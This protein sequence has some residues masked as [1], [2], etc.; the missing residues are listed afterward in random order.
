MMRL[1]KQ[2]A[3]IVANS[4]AFE[5]FVGLLEHAGGEQ[6]NLFR[7]LT[8]HR[9][10]EPKAYP[11]LDPGLISA[12]PETFEG[13]MKYLATNYQVVSVLDVVEAFENQ[14]R[15][16]L[17]LR[18]VMITF[19]DA[20][21][22]FEKHAWPILKYYR[23]PVTL[24]VPTAFPDHPERLFWWDRVFNAIHTTAK[25]E[26]NTSIGRIPISTASQRKQAF[27]RL[28]NHFKVLPN[29]VA[30]KEVEQL[31][32]ELGVSPQSNRVLGW[33]SLRKLASE[34]VTLGA[35]TRTHPIMNNIT[36]DDLHNETAGSRQ[37]LLREI[38]SV[39]QVFAYPSGVYNKEVVKAAERA[40]FALAFTT[41]RGIN[42]VGQVDRFRLRRINVGTRTTLPMLRAQLLSWTANL[43]SLS[44]SFF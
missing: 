40:G 44:E 42:E 41:E 11:W 33:D 15:I 21:S 12:S 8:Y 19:D 7:V 35:H 43:Y 14:G 32:S 18:A 20:Y 5:K 29:E 23:I 22:D 9:V 36:H 10:D 26:L 34:G 17:P 16:A 24:F 31:C 37:D 4:A 2:I 25:G 28:K 27:K 38:G 6:E 3:P 1:I 13:Q 30:V 39:P